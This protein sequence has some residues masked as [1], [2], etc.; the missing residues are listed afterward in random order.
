MG[1]MLTSP[2]RSVSSLSEAR[3]IV[4]AMAEADA[5]PFRAATFFDL[6]GQAVIAVFADGTIREAEYVARGSERWVVVA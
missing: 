4:A 1:H 5:L 2:L 6:L 3:A